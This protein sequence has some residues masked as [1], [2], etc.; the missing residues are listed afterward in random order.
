MVADKST[1]QGKHFGALPSLS[2]IVS[3]TRAR[4]IYILSLLSLSLSPSWLYPPRRSISLYLPICPFF[5]CLSLSLSLSLFR[6][7][8]RLYAVYICIYMEC[9]SSSLD[10][11]GARKI[12]LVWPRDWWCANDSCALCLSPWSLTKLVYSNR[13]RCPYRHTHAHRRVVRAD[14]GGPP[15]M[16]R[17]PGPAEFSRPARRK[18]DREKKANGEGWRERENRAETRE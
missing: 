6:T 1:S 12:A 4:C 18:S 11:V 10:D 16:T 9:E 8:V 3:R 5:L 14:R 2:L 17:R 13:E 15:T 7:C